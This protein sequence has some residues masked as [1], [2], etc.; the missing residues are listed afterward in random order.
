[1][2]EGP[3]NRFPAWAVVGLI[4]SHY[5]KDDE[6]FESWTKEIENFLNKDGREEVADYIHCVRTG[7]GFV[8]MEE[9]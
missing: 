3:I 5:E 8:P 2:T 1:M 9:V 6:K 4:Q 7:T